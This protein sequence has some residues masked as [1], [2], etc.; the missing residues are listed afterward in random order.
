MGVELYNFLLTQRQLMAV[1]VFILGCI[2]GSFLNVCIYRIPRRETVITTPSHCPYCKHSIRWYDN[3]PLLSYIFLQGKCRSCGNRI[4]LRYPLVEGLTAVLYLLIFLQFG[5]SRQTL[6]YLLFVSLL[7]VCSFTDL[8]R[9][10]NGELYLM[11][12]DVVTVPGAVA[13]VFISLVSSDLTLTE[14]LLGVVVGGGSLYLVMRIVPGGMGE[15]DTKLAAMMGA[16]LGWKKMLLGL[17]MGVIIGALVGVVLIIMKLKGRKDTIPFGPSLAAG[18]VL[19][20]FYGNDIISR[21]FSFS[22]P[23]P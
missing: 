3:I 13:G 14:S 22:I 6:A 4:S 9:D 12:P 7:L 10:E 8:E 19:A 20:V 18:A 15:G 5:P 23:S 16:F 11:I 1:P 2:M 17:Y 21:F